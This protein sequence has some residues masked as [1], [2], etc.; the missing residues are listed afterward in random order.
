MHSY[1]QLN[2]QF[3]GLEHGFRQRVESTP[4]RRSWDFAR[5][6]VRAPA[7]VLVAVRVSIVPDRT[8]EVSYPFTNHPGT[9]E[10]YPAC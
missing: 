4:F 8:L 3:P 6:T 1:S 7:M 10:Y 9:R 2:P 5:P